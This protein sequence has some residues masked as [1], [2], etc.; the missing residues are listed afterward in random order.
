MFLIEDNV[1]LLSEIKQEN[2]D[3]EKIVHDL[4]LQ[5]ENIYESAP[6]RKRMRLHQLSWEEK[7]QRK[8]L[9]NRIAAQTS[10]DRK[11]A[12]MDYLEE[13]IKQ[14]K[15]QNDILIMQVE[16]LKQRNETLLDT[17][18]QLQKELTVRSYTCPC[19]TRHSD[20]EGRVDLSEKSKEAVRQAPVKI[21]HSFNRPAVSTELPQQK[22]QWAIVAGGETFLDDL[23]RLAASLLEEVEHYGSGEKSLANPKEVPVSDRKECI[24]DS[25]VVGTTSEFMESSES[26]RSLSMQKPSFNFTDL[27]VEDQICLI[28]SEHSY[29]HVP[30]HL[31]EVICPMESSEEVFTTIPEITVSES[32]DSVNQ[33]MS[34]SSNYLFEKDYITVP[35]LTSFSSSKSEASSDLGYESHGSP[36]GS[37]LSSS[38]GEFFGDSLPELFPELI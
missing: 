3:Y 13:S 28:T 35:Q 11:K 27:A 5:N 2:M 34:E 25:Q 15:E 32:E 14:L 30:T 31:Q 7:L 6:V 12:K 37:D 9:R 23:E 8:K 19:F 18:E 22:G 16:E 38:F 20:A 1:V 10:R 4:D 36:C 33:E 24:T 17:N 29:A 26:G 21:A